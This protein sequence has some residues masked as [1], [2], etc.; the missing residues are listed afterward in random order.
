MLHNFAVAMAPTL[1]KLS[2]LAGKPGLG[3]HCIRYLSEQTLKGY[4]EE[5]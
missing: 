2:E 5:E 1:N 3:D 4:Q